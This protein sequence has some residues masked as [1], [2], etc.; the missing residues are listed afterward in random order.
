[1][2]RRSKLIII[3]IAVITILFVIGI[4][5]LII[6]KN[7]RD[8]TE[9]AAPASTVPETA[10]PPSAEQTPENSVPA[11]QPA[12]KDLTYNN[13]DGL[14]FISSEMHPDFKAAFEQHLDSSDLAVSSVL[15]TGTVTTEDE[16]FYT[17]WLLLDSDT[18]LRGTFNSN[19]DKYAFDL[20]LDADII[21]KFVDP[22]PPD[23]VDD[24]TVSYSYADLTISNMDKLEAALPEE[25]FLRFPDALQNYLDGLPDLRKFF[26]LAFIEQDG[27]TVSW[28]CVF[29]TPRIDRKNITATYSEKNDFSFSLIG[30]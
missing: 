23:G 10:V 16:R 20:E 19:N 4:T 22:G 8:A 7:P 1:M 30:D 9:T 28:T 27:D 12:R 14:Y 3:V 5:A 25:A 29:D 26:T 18:V 21:A 2:E 13:I 6:N 15:F 11:T 17:F 24:P